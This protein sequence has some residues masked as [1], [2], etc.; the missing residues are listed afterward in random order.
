MTEAANQSWYWASLPDTPLRP[1]L[2]GDAECDIGVVGGGIAGLSAALHLAGRG[3]R[4]TLLEAERIGWGASGRSGAQ[5][6]FGVAAGQEKLE[7]LIGAGD[8]RHVWDMSIEALALMRELISLHGIDCDY[9]AGQMHVAIKP[10]QLTELAEWCRDLRSSYAYDSV[11]LLNPQATRELVASERYI[12]GMLDTNSGHIHPLKYVRGLAAASERAG[13]VI[14]E[15]SRALRH[16]RRNGR[17][18]LVTAH[19]SLT[20]RH[21]VFAGN[22]WLGSTEPALA[23]RIMPVGTY[24]V[25]T[26][27]LG[28]ATAKAL[29]PQNTAVTDI[30]WVLDY[31]R[32]SSDHRLLF[33]GRVSY[34]GL[35]PF[36]T[37][38]ATR[39]RMLAVF[40]QLKGARIDY[41]WGGYVDITMNRAPDFG[42]LAPDVYYLQGFSGHGIALTG[43]AGKLVAEAIAG[44][45]E[46]FDV[47]ARIPH[48]DFPGGALLRRPALVLAMLYYRLRDLL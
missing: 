29:L 24:I 46:R 47:F 25:A 48:G 23:R 12:G 30:N 21:I 4:V 37:A 36:N 14:H 34:S 43:L 7:T 6:I 28:E 20:C 10:R 32:R 31:F 42:R 45:A 11:Q 13:C 2:A 8:A 41:A 35:D 40:P 19:G 22:A 9:V 18:V 16:E 5:A 1:S 17:P 39:K 15:G 3:Y 33:G 38:E 27:P 44:S 26:E